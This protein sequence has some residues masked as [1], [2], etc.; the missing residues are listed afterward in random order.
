MNHKGKVLP[1]APLCKPPPGYLL[2]PEHTPGSCPDGLARGSVP[3]SL[4]ASRGESKHVIGPF[5]FQD[6][7]NLV[8]QFRVGALDRGMWESYERK[9]ALRGWAP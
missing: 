4:R 6:L 3:S 5:T 7:G 1:S 8:Y 9:F 2:L